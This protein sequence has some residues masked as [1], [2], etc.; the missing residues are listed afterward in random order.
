VSRVTCKSCNHISKTF[1]PFLDL[2][3]PIIPGK[4]RTVT[5]CYGTFSKDEDIKDSYTCEKCKV[6]GKAS[7][8]FTVC[9]F[10]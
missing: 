6:K 2:S 5:E 7:K 3:L 9:R 4:T 10:P 8:R 1:D